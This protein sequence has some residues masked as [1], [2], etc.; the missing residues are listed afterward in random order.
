MPVFKQKGS[1]LYA[2]MDSIN[3]ELDRQEWIGVIFKSTVLWMGCTYG[4][5]QEEK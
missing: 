2:P 5:Y 3:Q 1:V 4:L